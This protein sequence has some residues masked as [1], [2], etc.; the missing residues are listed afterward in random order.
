MATFASEIFHCGAVHDAKYTNP[1]RFRA[2]K[3][4]LPADGEICMSRSGR[5]PEL[6]CF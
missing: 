1:L 3:I 5:I 2:G 4:A 6:R